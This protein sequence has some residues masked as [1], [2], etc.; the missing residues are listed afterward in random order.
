MIYFALLPERQAS[1]N[2]GQ[3]IEELM[4]A[5]TIHLPRLTERALQG[6]SL[7]SLFDHSLSLIDTANYDVA[8]DLKHSNVGRKEK[9]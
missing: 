6:P 7:R 3:N 4:A 2:V 5:G 9:A 1:T 8:N